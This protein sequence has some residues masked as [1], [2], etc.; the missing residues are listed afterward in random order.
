M[1]GEF[2]CCVRLFVPLL[3]KANGL[4]G[5]AV[6][7]S[8]IS[9]SDMKAKSSSFWSLPPRLK[10]EF[11]KIHVMSNKGIYV[12]LLGAILLLTDGFL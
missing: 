4:P 10:T 6:Q 2:T 3:W 9:P 1:K 12:K 5:R 8:F 11:P 7:D